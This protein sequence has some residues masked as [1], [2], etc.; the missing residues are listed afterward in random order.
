MREEVF[1]DVLWDVL[2]I[3]GSLAALSCTAFHLLARRLVVNH[4]DLFVQTLCCDLS[5]AFKGVLDGERHQWKLTA[6]RQKRKLEENTPG[7]MMCAQLHGWLIFLAEHLL[8]EPTTG[9]SPSC[10][11]ALN[12]L[13]LLVRDKQLHMGRQLD[14]VHTSI[15]SAVTCL[16][17][18]S[19]NTPLTVFILEAGCPSPTSFRPLLS[20]II[21]GD[22]QK[23]PVIFQDFTRSR[24]HVETLLARLKTYPHAHLTASCISAAIL[25]IDDV[26]R[27]YSGTLE[28]KAYRK[29]LRRRLDGV[30]QTIEKADLPIPRTWLSAS[31]QD[32]SS[33][34]KQHKGASLTNFP[35]QSV[36]V[37]VQPSR[38]FTTLVSGALSNRVSVRAKRRHPSTSSS[39]TSPSPSGKRRRISEIRY[40]V[41]S[42]NV[43]D[44]EDTDVVNHTC[45]K[46]GQVR[47]NSPMKPKHTLHRRRACSTMTSEADSASSD[48]RRARPLKPPSTPARGRRT[49]QHQS[50]AESEYHSEDDEPICLSSDPIDFLPRRRA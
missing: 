38:T 20:R 36:S 14:S 49:A 48:S 46:L 42:E 28:V 43:S 31:L 34:I 39:G 10:E 30:N 50:Y 24:Y 27:E 7:S 13:F 15:C 1:L 5:G 16:A 35:S 37:S 12:R 33:R 23:T 41:D 3:S 2:E 8:S 26:L 11:T 22:T 25:T 29:Q 6:P 45:A 44:E 40:H 9:L 21:T 18:V 17:A 47:P 4:V 19:P 32:P